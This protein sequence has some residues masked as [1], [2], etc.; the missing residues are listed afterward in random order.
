MKFCDLY[1]SP[2]KV[3]MAN[4]NEVKIF[5]DDTRKQRVI[6]QS[7]SPWLPFVVLVTKK[8]DATRFC[9]YYGKL[10][11][12]TSKD[13]YLLPRIDDT[14]DCLSGA[15]W[16][17]NLDLKTAYWQVEMHLEDKENRT[18]SANTGLWQ[19]NVMQFGLCNAPAH[20]ERLMEI[21]FYKHSLRINVWYFL[22][23]LG[24]K[25]FGEGVVSGSQNSG[26]H[27]PNYFEGS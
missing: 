15:K 10:N 18:F 24:S 20:F 22:M 12:V 13:S 8:D 16:F 3:S 14:L 26:P 7:N 25:G 1:T 21:V 27:I 17:S 23:M 9:V 5:I 19:F 2:K 11:E 4:P 6:E